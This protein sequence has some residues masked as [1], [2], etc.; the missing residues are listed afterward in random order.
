MN[1]HLTRV[2]GVKLLFN[3]VDQRLG[4]E[5]QNDL[6]HEHIIIENDFGMLSPSGTGAIYNCK[7]KTKRLLVSIMI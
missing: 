6:R 3:N 5:K 2:A 7:L 4:D 1:L